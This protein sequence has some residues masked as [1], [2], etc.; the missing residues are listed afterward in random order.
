MWKRSVVALV[1][2]GT[3]AAL[4]LLAQRSGFPSGPMQEKAQGYCLACH[5]AR[6]TV[7]QRL[8]RAGWTRVLDKMIR[9]GT[10]IEPADREP[11][12]DYF[13]E[14]FGPQA[15]AVA[16]ARLAEG[17]GAAEVQSTCLGCHDAGRILVAPRD[18]RA[19]ARLVAQMERFGAPVADRR[20]A[21]L[22]Y[23]SRHYAPAPRE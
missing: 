12:V 10:P 22:D 3:L 7:Q 2:A 6:I 20:G 1:L 23:L 4:P 19:W 15:D 21:I 5:D 17:P 13:T 18:R 16:P 9:W 11:L 14:H 8:D